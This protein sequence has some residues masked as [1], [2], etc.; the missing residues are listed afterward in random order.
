MRDAVLGSPVEGD[1]D[2][3]TDADPGRI[4]TLLAGSADALWTQGERFG[5]IG[6]RVG[7][8]TYEITTHRSD[9]YESG[10]RKPVVRFT[11]ALE[12]DLARRDFTVNAMALRLP[13]GELVDPFGGATDLAAGVLR[14]PLEPEVSFSDD[15]LRM[16]RA[17][18]FAA[19]LRLDPR[20]ELVAA[21]AAMGDRL[22]IVSVERRRAELDRLLLLDDP[23]PG[24]ELLVATGLAQRVV[25]EL[26]ADV[27]A[28]V[29]R[30]PARLVPRLATLLAGLGEPGAVARLRA[31][32]S[33][34]DQ[35]DAVRRVVAA[36]G[37]FLLRA[38][39][40]PAAGGP[41]AEEAGV[42]R[43]AGAAGAR[44][45]DAVATL[46]ARRPDLGEAVTATLRRLAASGDLDDLRPQL[47]GDEVQRL[48]DVRPG[49]IV[50]EALAFLQEQRWEH[51]TMD[52]AEVRRRLREWWEQRPASS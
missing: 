10:S 49:P 6:C 19:S 46:T 18:R 23:A 41:D 14:T 15:P 29:A 20:P 37:P 28:A 32:R 4:K 16:L 9:R 30:A 24:L 8:R 13:T 33:A 48:L 38:G 1:V 26:D 35:I 34:N 2:L 39:D 45:D 7:D 51:G 42:R 44:L 12:T 11:S 22:S 25:P 27:A 3:T 5:T 43:F 21:M 50:G 40:G 47:D 36:V 17:A 52:E 31:L